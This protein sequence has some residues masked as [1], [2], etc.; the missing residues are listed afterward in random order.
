MTGVR[1]RRFRGRGRRYGGAGRHGLASGVALLLVT[2][3]AQTPRAQPTRIGVVEVYGAQSVAPDD[4]RRAAGVIAG[5]AVAA[6]SVIEQRVRRLRGVSGAIVSVVCCESGRSI[7]YIGIQEGTRRFS[8]RPDPTGFV[9]MP[10]EVVEAEVEFGAA[11]QEAVTGG[12]TEEDHSA[13]HALMRDP[14]ARAVQ[15]RFIDLAMLHEDTLRRVLRESRF[16]LQRAL[17]AQV[18]GYLPDKRVAI[19]ALAPALTDP[20]PA[21]RNDA[22]RALWIIASFAHDKPALRAAIPAEPL[23]AMLHSL[24]WT[25]RNKAS[26]VLMALTA[27]RDTTLLE[28]L[29]ARARPA[30]EE[31]ARW[32]TQHAL[33]PHVILGR[34][35]GKPDDQIF[36]AWQARAQAGR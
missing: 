21:V 12:R 20:S 13:G 18:L 17:A 28:T 2:L 25:D 30:L 32:R 16:P 5:D 23:I 35:D 36:A 33:A 19:E 10:D 29:G 31:M 14:R 3:A 11:L 9:A 15:Q 7:V 24:H 26:L 27:S 34:I 4:V 8:V 22:A 6:D 1:F